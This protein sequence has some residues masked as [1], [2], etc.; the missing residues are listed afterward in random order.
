MYEKYL[1]QGIEDDIEE[2]NNENT[3]NAYLHFV[4]M[5]GFQK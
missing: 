4:N 3:A 5:F 2:M 1:E